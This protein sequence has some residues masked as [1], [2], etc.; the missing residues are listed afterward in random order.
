MHVP[1]YSTFGFQPN[2]YKNMAFEIGDEVT[3]TKTGERYII[4][5]K[6]SSDIAIQEGSEIFSIGF[7]FQI[8]HLNADI[9]SPPINVKKED[10]AF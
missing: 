6:S 2:Y 3:F 1:I 9:M 4:T 10:L 8:R 5:G 7:D